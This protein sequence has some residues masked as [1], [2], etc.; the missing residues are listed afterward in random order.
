MNYYCL[1]V[2]NP[3]FFWR[4]RE[5]LYSKKLMPQNNDDRSCCSINDP[6]ETQIS[7]DL[8]RI[9]YLVDALITSILAAGHSSAAQHDSLKPPHLDHCT[10]FLSRL[11]VSKAMEFVVKYFFRNKIIALLHAHFFEGEIFF[12]VGSESHHV[13]LENMIMELVAS[14]K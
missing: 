8:H 5:A 1:F 11:S 2:S 9:N 6:S 3:E 14:G 4:S 13:C 10:A 7:N 12:G